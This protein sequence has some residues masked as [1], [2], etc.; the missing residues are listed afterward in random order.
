MQ[1]R[2]IGGYGRGEEGMVLVVTIMSFTMLIALGSALLVTTITETSI[3]S[4]H[5]ESSRVFYAAEAAANYVV[6]DVTA[7]RDWG[8]L[9]AEDVTSSFVDGPPEGTRSVGSATID[10]ATATDEIGVMSTSGIE[11]TSSAWHLYAFGR[12]ADMLPDG[13]DLL[14]TYVIAWIAEPSSEVDM[15]G[16]RADHDLLRIVGQA[17]GPRG[18]RRTVELTVARPRFTEDGEAAPLE[19]ISWRELR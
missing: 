19:V 5:H 3:A 18:S 8:A 12:F 11:G 4:S 10:L 14:P 17:R 7:V 2:N 9:L 1:P 15:A 6:A 13:E 16:P